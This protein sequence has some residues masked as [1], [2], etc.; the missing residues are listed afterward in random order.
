MRVLLDE[1]VPRRLSQ[2]LPN[3]EVMTV[4]QAG[5]S[6]TKNGALLKLASEN[7]DV[8]LTV[9]QNLQHQQDI[10]AL[11]LPIV[12]LV[13][14]SNDIADLQPLMASVRSL[15]PYIAPGSLNIIEN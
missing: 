3:H 5:W 2:E 8:F 10:K 4:V 7:F 12:V 9:D 14:N 1:C 11:P 15:L 13:A 6:G